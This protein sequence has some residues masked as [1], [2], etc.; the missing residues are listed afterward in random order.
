MSTAA[1]AL[2]AGAARLRAADIPDPVGDARRLLAHA[3][4][5]PPGRLT[6]VLADP[7]TNTQAARFED[8]IAARAARRPVS[9]ITGRRAFWGREF[10]TG[11]DVLDP[12]PETETLVAAALELEFARVLDLGTGSGCILLSLLAD[13]PA[14]HGTGTDRSAAALD[15]ARRNAAAL[16]LEDRATLV[17]ADWFDAVEGPFDLIVSNPPYIAA[18]EMAGLDPEVRD[19][20]PHEAL[21]PGGDGLD[22]YRAILAA[23]R[24]HM[25]PGGHLLLE[26]GPTQAGAVFALADAAGLRRAGLQR[27][28]DGR[29]R[30]VHLRA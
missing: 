1:R 13:R 30:V 20:E 27:D 16:G 7:I 29:D 21:T 14:S 3:L 19:W 24:G 11:P 22:A 17:Q 5:I 26:I 9:Q 6:L 8:A 15:V 28:M 10:I 25:T 12:R 18:G 4:V 2:A 23:A